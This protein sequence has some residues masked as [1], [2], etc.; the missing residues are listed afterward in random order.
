MI[1]KIKLY[2]ISETYLKFDLEYS[3][4]NKTKIKEAYLKQIGYKSREF[5]KG[6]ETINISIEYEEGSLKTK[7]IVWALPVYMGIAN[8]GSFRAGVR[9]IVNDA[10]HFSKF[11][12]EKIDDDV[13]INRHDII[14]TECRTGLPGR[15]QELYNKINLLERNANNL[16][17]VEIQ[18]ELNKI[19]QDISNIKEL[20]TEEDREAFLNDLGDTYNQNLPHPNEKKTTYLI[21]RYGIKPDEFIEFINE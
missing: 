8:Y 13:Q 5:F 11:V 15:L 10:K 19:K 16:S 3:D 17:N 18:V 9:E 4:S 21:N 1:S 20:L 6:S 7:I 12:I 2:N 14:R